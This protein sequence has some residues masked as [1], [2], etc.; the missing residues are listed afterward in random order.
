MRKKWIAAL[1]SVAMVLSL[2]T[3]CGASGSK[4]TSGSIAGTYE[5]TGNGRNGDIVVAV[6]LDDNA[7]I[8][9]NTKFHTL[10]LQS[11][12]NTQ[13]HSR[14][15]HQEYLLLHNLHVLLLPQ[16]HFPSQRL[17]HK[18]ETLEYHLHCHQYRWH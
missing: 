10:I 11:I 1:L 9:N 4:A 6:T 16:Q 17:F 14:Y 13:M 5:G 18:P 3:G 15:H 2:L 12:H 8:T 7:A